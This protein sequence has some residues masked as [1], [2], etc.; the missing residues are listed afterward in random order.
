MIGRRVDQVVLELKN[1]HQKQITALEQVEKIA[2]SGETDMTQEQVDSVSGGV[3]RDATT[4]FPNELQAEPHQDPKPEGERESKRIKQDHYTSPSG[5]NKQERRLDGSQL[6][7]PEM[8]RQS[9]RSNRS[10][11]SSDARGRRPDERERDGSA[12]SFSNN[13]SR[14]NARQDDRATMYSRRPRSRD[15]LSDRYSTSNS[16]VSRTTSDRVSERRTGE[17]TNRTS[18]NEQTSAYDARRNRDR[19]TDFP[20]TRESYAPSRRS[21]DGHQPEPAPQ[22]L[23]LRDRIEGLP[24]RRASPPPRRMSPPPVSEREARYPPRDQSR[25]NGYGDRRGS[26]GGNDRYPDARDA[27]SNDL[28]FERMNNN[29]VSRTGSMPE[30][31]VSMVCAC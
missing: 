1:N 17:N 27:G 11:L 22:R 25:N 9:S 20:P 15:G 31:L 29:P 6:L 13:N 5:T 26:V 18:Q 2:E 28:A 10:A 30:R 19:E 4:S 12:R 23:A 3:K 7:S 21:L 8:K 16:F 24:P 14:N